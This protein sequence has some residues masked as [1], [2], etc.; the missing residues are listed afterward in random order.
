MLAAA[1]G[2]RSSLGFVVMVGLSGGS[3]PWWG[4]GCAQHLEGMEGRVKGAPGGLPCLSFPTCP[5]LEHIGNGAQDRG[6]L[7]APST[8]QH[9]NGGGNPCVG[10]GSKGAIRRDGDPHPSQP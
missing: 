2:L 5:M 9:G 8:L 7:I 1:M 4:W 3:G 10:P 6:C